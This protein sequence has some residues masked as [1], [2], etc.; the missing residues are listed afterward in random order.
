M[1]LFVNFHVVGQVGASSVLFRAMS[2][3]RQL[4]MEDVNLRSRRY[5]SWRPNMVGRGGDQ[6][7][8]V[9]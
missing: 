5:V 8:Y 7:A 2:T 4:G 1:F 6:I 3:V 9:T